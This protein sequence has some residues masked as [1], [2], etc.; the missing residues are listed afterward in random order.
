[1]N[2]INRDPFEAYIRHVE[3]NRKDLG[4]AWY[5]AIGLQAVDSLQTSAYLKEI[6]WV[7]LQ[8]LH[9]RRPRNNRIPGAVSQESPPGGEK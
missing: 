6:V 2:D 3:P 1:M 9:Q 8:Q 7:Q 5:T 4:Y